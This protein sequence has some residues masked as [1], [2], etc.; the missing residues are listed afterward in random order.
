M[1]TEEEIKDKINQL[2]TDASTKPKGIEK[3]ML[4]FASDALQWVISK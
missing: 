4:K 1:K 2:D 3:E